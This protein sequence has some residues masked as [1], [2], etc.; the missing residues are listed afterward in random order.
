MPN[1]D[2]PNSR[3]E[4]I[5]ALKERY[6]RLIDATHIVESKYAARCARGDAMR[7]KRI[8]N[9]LDTP[10]KKHIV[11]NLLGF[12]KLLLT[13]EEDIPDE[14]LPLVA[15]KMDQCEE[16]LTLLEHHEVCN[17]EFGTVD[18]FLGKNNKI[19]D[20]AAYIRALRHRLE[21]MKTILKPL[22]DRIHL[23]EYKFARI[24]EEFGLILG[25]GQHAWHITNNLFAVAKGVLDQLTNEYN[26]LTQEERQRDE[27][28]ILEYL[29][30]LDTY[31]QLLIK[32]KD[33]GK[34]E[35]TKIK[36]MFPNL[37]ALSPTLFIPKALHLLEKRDSPAT[38]EIPPDFAL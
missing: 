26:E 5:A 1:V 10:H 6:N 31:A 32:H 16:Y 37:G 12:S 38:S 7:E 20:A 21:E 25:P 36:G 18:G 34:I 13:L 4:Q 19:T 35:F 14:Q 22:Q 11:D 27:A 28:K 2:I 3:S 29:E 9:G 23:V 33:F 17:K 8:Q 30:L 24:A 15:E